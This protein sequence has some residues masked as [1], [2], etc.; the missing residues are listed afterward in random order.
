T[1]HTNRGAPKREAA[2]DRSTAAPLWAAIPDNGGYKVHPV[3][4]PTSTREE[5][6]N[7]RNA[8]SGAPTI[9]GTNQLP[10]PPINTGITMKK[11]MT[12]AWAYRLT[13][14]ATQI[15]GTTYQYHDGVLS[16][17]TDVARIPMS[18]SCVGDNP[19]NFAFRSGPEPARSSTRC[20][21]LNPMWDIPHSAGGVY[22]IVEGRP[23]RH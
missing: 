19:N 21:Q 13:R 20:F 22:T 15:L 11:I 2:P 18:N 3:P 4:A 17:S 8:M 9:T 10:N 16:T 12:T 14:L 1:D 5:D 6:N 7:K 23:K